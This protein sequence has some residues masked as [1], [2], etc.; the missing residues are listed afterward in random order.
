MVSANM[1]TAIDTAVMKTTVMPARRS[2]VIAVK[3]SL[4]SLC[5]TRLAVSVLTLTPSCM[6][7]RTALSRRTVRAFSG[8]NSLPVDQPINQ[9][10]R[11]GF[12]PL[13]I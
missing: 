4:M 7:D 9:Q 12:P 2:R 6:L 3:T 10:S 11:E 13:G 8:G 1:A 5:M